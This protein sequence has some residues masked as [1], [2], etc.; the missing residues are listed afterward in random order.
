MIFSRVLRLISRLQDLQVEWNR[1][2]HPRCPSLRACG[3]Q[4]KGKGKGLAHRDISLHVRDIQKFEQQAPIAGEVVI[5]MKKN[6]P[7]FG[8]PWGRWSNYDMHIFWGDGWLHH[9]GLIIDLGWYRHVSFADVCRIF[10]F[11]SQPLH[12]PFFY[13]DMG[14]TFGKEY[15]LLY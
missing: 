12:T 7:K 13:Q 15:H 8:I 2:A 11:F 4:L 6:M 9:H 3:G 5:P 10:V 14:S 1:I